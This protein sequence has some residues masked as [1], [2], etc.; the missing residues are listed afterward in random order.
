MERIQQYEI[1]GLLGS[2]GFGVVFEARDPDSPD[3]P[4]AIKVLHGELARDQELATRFFQE[5][6]VLARLDHASIPRVY[7]FGPWK[8][9]YFLVQELVRGEAVSEAFRERRATAEEATSLLRQLLTGLTYAHDKGIV[10]R[11]LK[12][13]NLILTPG[14]LK[15][16]DFG[17]ARIL[18]GVRLTHSGGFL[19]S[20]PYAAPEQL[21]ASRVDGRADLFSAGILLHRL[22]TGQL[23]HTPRAPD[24]ASALGEQLAWADRADRGSLRDLVPDVPAALDRFYRTATAPAPSDRYASAAEA[25]ADLGGPIAGSVAG[26]VTGSVAAPPRAPSPGKSPVSAGS[27]G[28]KVEV[29]CDH[30]AYPDGDDPII[31]ALVS[32]EASGVAQGPEVRADV[33]LVLDVSGSMN[34]P[35]KYPLLRRAVDEFLG[36]MSLTDRVGIV[37]FST[38]A[39]TITSLLPGKEAAARAKKLLTKMD[40]SKLLWGS[41]NLAPGLRLAEAGLING[42]GG[43]VRRIYVLTDGE[44][45]D[46]PACEKVLE[47]FR[48]ERIE[49]SVYGFGSGFNGA[50]LKQLVS[51]QLGGSVK[52]ICNEKDIV[53]TFAHIAAVNRRLLAEDG[54]ISFDVDPGVDAGDAWSFRPQERHLGPIHHRR[55]VREIGGVEAARVYSFL[56]ELRIPPHEGQRSTPLGRVTLS[57]RQGRDRIEVSQQIA[58]PRSPGG[59][60]AAQ[61]AVPAVE[62]AYAILDAMRQGDNPQA[63]LAATRARLSLAKLEN[64]DPGLIEALQ[65]QLDV[66]EGRRSE[67]SLTQANQQ[68]LASDMSSCI[69]SF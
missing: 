66:L 54:L 24:L 46:S 15:L 3:K 38:D 57:C 11:D 45:F 13:E 68:Y 30:V 51:D 21:R 36:R 34:T 22:L 20:I 47:P 63:S 64:R 33:F 31:Q 18:E 6:L 49:V 16:L 50:A 53:D 8:E 26:A 41:T 43:G 60:G 5:A 42:E 12:P 58:A 1:V 35:D 56:F 62:Q 7:S 10:H 9:T 39:E 59:A 19:G 67:G 32:I 17:L 52:P 27:L 2:G 29:S 65:G 25:L 55:V 4:L 14:G 69:I 40:G 23:P 48:K 61:A 44:I 37:V 28:L